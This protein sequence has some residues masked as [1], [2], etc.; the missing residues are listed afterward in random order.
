MTSDRDFNTDDHNPTEQTKPPDRVFAS[1]G[2]GNSGPLLVVIGGI[3][4]N[5]PSGLVATDRVLSRLAREEIPID[6]RIIALAGNRTALLQGVRFV[7]QD[8]NRMW[9]PE[10]VANT[11]ERDPAEDD[12]EQREQRELVAFIDNETQDHHGQIIVIDLHSTSSDSPPFCI[13]SDTLQN[14]RVAFPLLIPVILGLEESI[15]GTIQNYW[16]DRGYVTAALEGGQ[17]DAPSTIDRLESAL[18]IMLVAIGLVTRDRIADLE[19][20]RASLRD[21]SRGLPR[22]VEVAHRHGIVESDGFRMIDGFR[23]F[24]P[25]EEGQPLAHDAKGEIRAP[26]DGMLVMPSYQ[27]IG[28][29]GFFVGRRVRRVW[30][31]ISTVVRRLRLDR[32]LRWLPGVRRHPTDQTALLADPSVARWPVLKVFHVCG[33]RKCGC[34][35]GLL[36]FKRR[37]DQPMR[38]RR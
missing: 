26:L 17:H 16:D 9:L 13:I 29:D 22:V 19:D 11:L 10:Q 25:I 33:F 2:S 20:H 28:D 34:N 35:N 18:L 30:L 7:D 23:N 5:E 1:Y 27:S 6:G 4:G 32:G 24:S 21:L 38:L 15:T 3:H 8:L 37:P 36:C 14:R 31:R 12:V